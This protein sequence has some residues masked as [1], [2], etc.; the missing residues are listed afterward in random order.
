MSNFSHTISFSKTSTGMGP[1][2]KYSLDEFLWNNNPDILFLNQL[3]KINAIKK[4][5]YQLNKHRNKMTDLNQNE[6]DSDL[7]NKIIEAAIDY[8]QGVNNSGFADEFGGLDHL[9]KKL[10]EIIDQYQ[11]PDEKHL[12]NEMDAFKR[13]CI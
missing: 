8:R 9:R 11:A 6:I 12:L 13:L 3:I 2:L 7:Q 4:N 1:D 5:D 10:F